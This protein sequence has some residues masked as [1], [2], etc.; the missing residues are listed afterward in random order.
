MKNCP[1]CGAVSF[2]NITCPVCRAELQMIPVARSLFR[3]SSIRRPSE[4]PVGT[5]FHR[6]IMRANLF[7]GNGRM[8][9]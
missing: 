4:V 8:W 9:R 3:G 1:L 5:V 7:I 2:G 6:R